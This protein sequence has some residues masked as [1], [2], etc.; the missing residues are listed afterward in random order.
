MYLSPLPPTALSLKKKKPSPSAP[1]PAPGSLFSLRR[2]KEK[3]VPL[4]LPQLVRVLSRARSQKNKK[5][6]PQNPKNPKQASE[7]FL[8]NGV[9][10]WGSGPTG[11]E[12]ERGKAVTW[13]RGRRPVFARNSPGSPGSPGTPSPTGVRASKPRPGQELRHP[14]GAR[15]RCREH[16]Y[17]SRRRL[18]HGCQSPLN[19]RTPPDN[20]R[21]ACRTGGRRSPSSKPPPA[22]C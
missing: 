11:K 10:R 9:W 22:P 5:Q 17:P 1:P 13:G 21:A 14:E 20:P 15:D 6:N 7:K 16:P 19:A 8:R 3:S 4:P 2:K 18:R 12:P